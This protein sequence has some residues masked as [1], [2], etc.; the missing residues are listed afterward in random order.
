MMVIRNLSTPVRYLSALLALTVLSACSSSGGGSRFPG[1]ANPPDFD[2][3]GGAELRSQMHRLA[4]ELQQ[5][6]LA[7]VGE[8]SGNER[9]R[10]LQDVI[11]NHLSDIERIG[12]DL[13]EGDLSSSHTFLRNDMD[14]FLSTVSRARRAAE[15][16]PPAY[17]MAGRVSGACVNC[18]QT[19]Q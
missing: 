8:D 13:R 18:H 3:A 7:L 12:S 15:G 17:Y 19:R 16:N 5:L 6:D 4:F 2:Y 1:I 14:N 11:V 9:D 10:G